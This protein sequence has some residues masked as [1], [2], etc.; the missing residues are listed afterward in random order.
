MSRYAYTTTTIHL[1]FASQHI[2]VLQAGAAVS[3]HDVGTAQSAAYKPTASFKDCTNANLDIPPSCMNISVG[4]LQIEGLEGSKQALADEALMGKQQIE[5]LQQQLG[6]CQQELTKMQVDFSRCLYA[7]CP[8]PPFPPTFGGL[9][10]PPHLLPV[11]PSPL[12]SAHCYHGLFMLLSLVN[13]CFAG[14]TA[15]QSR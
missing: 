7:T 14:S 9:A 10:P 6:G 13:A 8:P 5:Y 1:V 11:A 15:L 4:V 3:G 12:C 2:H